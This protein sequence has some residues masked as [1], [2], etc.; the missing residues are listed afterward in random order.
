MAFLSF[1]NDKNM[2][3]SIKLNK[4]NNNTY[5]SNMLY[6]YYI[7]EKKNLSI[8]N[9]KSHNNRMNNIL[10][11]N[12]K[13]LRLSSFGKYPEIF[14]KLFFKTKKIPSNNN[15]SIRHYDMKSPNLFL[16][17]SK[18]KYP[19]KISKYK[20]NNTE[21]NNS[22]KEKYKLFNIRRQN[23]NMNIYNK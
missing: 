7:K 19:K 3:D 13:S 10:K 12:N 14:K 5:T 23:K 20:N 15:K 17:S 2:N 18:K 22:F 6:T 16:N 9:D 11:L 1:R 8:Q 4:L 21:N